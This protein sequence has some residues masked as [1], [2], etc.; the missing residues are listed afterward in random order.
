MVHSGFPLQGASDVKLQCFFIIILKE[1]THTCVSK[2]VN[3]GSDNGLLPGRRQTI[4][5]TSAGILLN[6]PSGINF[7]EIW[8]EIDTVSFEKMYLRMSSAKWRPSCRGLNAL[9][10]STWMSASIFTRDQFWPSGIVVAYVCL[11]VCVSVCV[12]INQMLVRAITHH[13]FKLGSPNLDHRC[14]RP[15]VRSLFFFFLWGGGGGIN[16]DLQRQIELQSQN[17]PHFQL[18]HDITHHQLKL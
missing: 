6:G 5:W 2:I 14:K 8:I 1:L 7:R 17:L 9:M 12:C 18:V 10:T 3:I 13:P 4:I 11:S 16:L 15:W